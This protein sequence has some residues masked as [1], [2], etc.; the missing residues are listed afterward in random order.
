RHWLAAQH[1]GNAWVLSAHVRPWPRLRAYD[2]KEGRK[3]SKSRSRTEEAVIVGSRVCGTPRQIPLGEK[4]PP[5]AGGRSNGM[6]TS[7]APISFED[8]TVEFTQDEWRHVGPAQR[9]LY[10]DVMLENY[11][12]LVSVGYCFIKP[13]VIFRLEQG[14][15]PWLLEDDFLKRSY[16]G[17]HTEKSHS[18]FKEDECSKILNSFSQV[19][20]L[21]TTD[22]RVQNFSQK[23]HFREYLRTHIGV[24]PLECGKLLSHSSAITAQQKVQENE[25]S[26]D[27]VACREPFNFQSSFNMHQRIHGRRKLY[28]HNHQKSL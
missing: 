21:Q 1:P 20:Q 3:E 14:K 9:A 18:E 15:D 25:T 13:K 16:P 24:Q 23:A 12:H 4:P 5:A 17:S 8:V 11:S 2:R 22:T 7:Q 19:T 27:N 26:C 28:V 10:R 6:D